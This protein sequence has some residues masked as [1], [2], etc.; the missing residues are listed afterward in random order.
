[1]LSYGCFAIKVLHWYFVFEITDLKT[2][3]LFSDMQSIT[4]YG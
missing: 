2:G 4:T 1:M 3:S